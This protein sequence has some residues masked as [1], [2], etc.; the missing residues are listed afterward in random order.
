MIFKRKRTNLNFRK[1]KVVKTGNVAKAEKIKRNEHHQLWSAIV[2]IILFLILI[3]IIS[4]AA[5]YF[6]VTWQQLADL[7]VRVKDFFVNSYNGVYKITYH[8][9]GLALIVDILI[10]LAFKLTRQFKKR[11]VSKKKR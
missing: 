10:L 7:F 5:V 4:A 2:K 1:K 11:M 9:A 8:L 6:N 3:A